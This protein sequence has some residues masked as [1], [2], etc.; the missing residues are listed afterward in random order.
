MSL[1]DIHCADRSHL[2]LLAVCPCPCRCSLSAVLQPGGWG[3]PPVDAQGNPLYGDVF[4][5][6]Q[7]DEDS[8]AGG[9]GAQRLTQDKQGRAQGQDVLLCSGSVARTGC[10]VGRHAA[11]MR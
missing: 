9:G 10:P 8:D 7:D 5:L 2:L 1:P 11:S 4:G 6:A 3:K